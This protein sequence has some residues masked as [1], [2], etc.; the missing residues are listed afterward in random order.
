MVDE[1]MNMKE[2]F[3]GSKNKWTGV[4]KKKWF[5]P[6]LYIVLAAFLLSG[7]IWYQN[8]ENKLLE[9]LDEMENTDDIQP[10]P[11]DQEEAESVLQQDETIKMPVKEDTKAEIVTKFYDYDADD[12][13]KEQAVTYY[14]NRYYQSTGVDIAAADGETFDVVAS[15]SGSVT[16]VKE[17]PLNGNIVVMDHGDD[18]TTYYASL[19]EVGVKAGDKVKQGD[20]LGTAGRSIFSEDSGTHV[21]FEIWKEKTE[22]NPE[23]FFNQSMAKLMEFEADQEVTQEKAESESDDQGSDNIDQEDGLDDQGSGNIDQEDGSDDESDDGTDDGTDE[24]TGEQTEEGQNLS[25]SVTT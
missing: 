4:F 9:G 24:D 16:E 22:V 13:A 17:D 25:F 23:N 1:V 14:H 8:V 2:N 20:T 7:V 3:N 10:N 5:F 18:I 21:H 11:F 12:E 6:A 19:E 15:L